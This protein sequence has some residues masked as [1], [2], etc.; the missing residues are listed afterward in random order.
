M[1]ERTKAGPRGAVKARGK[2]LGMPDPCGAVLAYGVARRAQTAQFAGQRAD[3]PL[4]SPAHLR[5]C[6][7]LGNGTEVGP[8]ALP[9]PI[10]PKPA[11]SS[12]RGFLLGVQRALVFHFPCSPQP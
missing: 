9:L 3:Q 8:R 6:R 4:P 12:L 5:V 11:R 2:R 10:P 7:I 1:S